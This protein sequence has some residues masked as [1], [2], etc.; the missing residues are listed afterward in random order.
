VLTATARN[1][2]AGSTS[3]LSACRAVSVPAPQ[4][5][6]V[7]PPP[8]GPPLTGQS[9]GTVPPPVQGVSFNAEPVRG[10]VTVTPPGGRRV[11]LRTLTTL[12]ARSVVD[13]RRGVVRIVSARGTATQSAVFSGGVF[14]VEYRGSLTVLRLVEDVGLASCPGARRGART[15]AASAPALK[16][17]RRGRRPHR[18]RRPR[19]G[20][21]GDGH[22][23]FQTVG[24]H[25]A[26]TVR[27]TRWLVQDTCA[28]TLTRVAR[29][30]VSV[31]DFGRRRTVTV[32]A[33]RRYLARPAAR[34]RR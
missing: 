21:W 32:R 28:G 5:P 3:E 11:P 19:R 17:G 22:G 1:T 24:Q 34:R 23:R 7:A 16:A 13:A 18:G 29:G 27:G 4:Q 8:V 2:A 20:L 31:R 10:T 33:G 12:P 25:S 26:T 9:R 6:P 15:A 14:R 30:V